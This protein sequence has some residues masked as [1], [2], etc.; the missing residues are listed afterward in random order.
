MI[1]LMFGI[2]YIALA[3]G[4]KLSGTV[5]GQI[6]EIQ[7]QHSLSYFF[8]MFTFA[9]VAIGLIGVFISPL[10]KKLMHGVK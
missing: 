9:L 1:A 8:M 6:E 3:I 4:N 7:K 5:G 10:V 2:W